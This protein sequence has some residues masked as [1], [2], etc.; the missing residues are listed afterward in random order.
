MELVLRSEE[1]ANKTFPQRRTCCVMIAAVI[2]GAQ[3]VLNKQ[4]R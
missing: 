3:T 1:E 4:S 2:W